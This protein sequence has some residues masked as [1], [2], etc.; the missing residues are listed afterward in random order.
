MPAS[1]DR[2]HREAGA[3]VTRWLLRKTYTPHEPPL[4]SQPPPGLTAE[5]IGESG[6]SPSPTAR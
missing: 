3:A 4:L 6:A 1:E 5:I 2:L